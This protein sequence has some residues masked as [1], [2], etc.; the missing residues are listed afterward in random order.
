MAGFLDHCGPLARV[1]EDIAHM[2][3]A[4][5][6]FDSKDITLSR[7]PV[8]DYLKSLR[9][10]VKEL[11][12]V[13]HNY[14]RD[15]NPEPEVMELVDKAIADLESLG[16]VIIEIVIPFME[17]ASMAASVIYAREFYHVC[18]SDL[19]IEKFKTSIR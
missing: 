4:I 5:P 19:H 16:A 9:E 10:N 7:V 1:V 17:H 6:V 2:L 12:V 8:P 18:K 3:Q 14:I 15:I 13:L 11:V